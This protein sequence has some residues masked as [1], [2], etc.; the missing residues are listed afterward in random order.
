[1]IVDFLTIIESGTRGCSGPKELDTEGAEI[2][3]SRRGKTSVVSAIFC[4]LR[5]QRPGILIPEVRP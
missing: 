3:R 4:A 5:V 1:M 2:R